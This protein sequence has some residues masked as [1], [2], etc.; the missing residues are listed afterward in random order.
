V[1]F[2]EYRTLTCCGEEMN[3]YFMGIDNGGTVTKAVIFDAEGQEIAA[4]SAKVPMLRPRPGFTERD[5]EALWQANVQVIREALALSGLAPEQ[6]RGVACT[7]HGKGLY[8]WGKDG[9]PAGNGIVST[10]A[11]AWEYPQQWERDGTAAKVFPRTMQTPLACQPVALWRWF[12]DHQP[13]LLERVQWVFEVKDYV[14]FRLTGEA[15]AEVTDYSGSSLMNLAEARFDRQLLRD[16]GVEDMFDKLPPLCRSTEVCGRITRSTAGLTGLRPGTPVAGG[17]FDIDACA[18]AMDVTTEENLCVIAGT[19]GINEYISRQPVLDKSIKLNSLFCL[20]GYFLIEESSPTS[21]SNN[22]WF[23]D[24]FLDS[25]KRQAEARGIGIHALAEELAASV[26]P[27]E[28]SILFLPF[29]YGSND[30]PQAKACFIGLDSS[31]TR[32]Q[33]IRSVL[34]GIVFSHR[35]HIQ[36]LLANRDRP[37]AI[38]LAGGAVNNRTWSQMFADVLGLPV[39]IIDTRELGALGCAMAAAVASGLY[40]DLQAAARSM[41]RVQQRLEPEPRN[42]A[43]YDRKFGLFAQACQALD[44]LWQA[45]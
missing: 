32:A 31:H 26:R 28:Q 24:L 22:E 38:R 4:A 43:I 34:E 33:V 39:E 15:R 9:K 37:G 10:D 36:R 18:V 14:R 12:Q 21:V 27:D 7:G 41:V 20:P 13:E 42:Q 19:W 8:L 3:N 5:M 11:R 45:F 44:S 6:I 16:F 1:R 29:L 2:D 23:T 17:M 40:P 25:E 30:N 35:V